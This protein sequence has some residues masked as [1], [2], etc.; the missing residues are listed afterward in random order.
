MPVEEEYSGD[1]GKKP[2]PRI[3]SFFLFCWN[4]VTF[5]I[6]AGETSLTNQTFFPK[7][8]QICLKKIVK[9]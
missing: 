2:S 8:A 5:A 1:Y 3:L 6:I 7:A 4:A 9:N